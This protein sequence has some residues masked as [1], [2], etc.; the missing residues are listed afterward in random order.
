M[1]ITCDKYEFTDGVHWFGIAIG[2]GTKKGQRQ[3]NIQFDLIKCA[4]V[5]SIHRKGLKFKRGV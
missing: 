5:F 4:V 2:I 3:L 1:E